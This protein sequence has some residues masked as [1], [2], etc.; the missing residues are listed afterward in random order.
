MVYYDL[1]HD[2]WGDWYTTGEAYG[3]PSQRYYKKCKMMIR[4]FIY[5]LTGDRDLAY[6]Q[7]KVASGLRLMGGASS[8]LRVLAITGDG[9]IVTHENFDG[10]DWSEYIVGF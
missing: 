3:A 9:Q 10:F 2:G 6:E 1:T 4:D 5:Q 8:T 7:P